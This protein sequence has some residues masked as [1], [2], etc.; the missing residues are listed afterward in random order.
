MSGLFL[1]I[2]YTEAGCFAIR[3]TAFNDSLR[4]VLKAYEDFLDSPNKN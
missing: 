4:N 2:M 3:N 1:W